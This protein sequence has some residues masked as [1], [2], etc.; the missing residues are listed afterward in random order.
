[1]SLPPLSS[2]ELYTFRANCALRVCVAVW[3]AG[4]WC[5]M[6]VRP[7]RRAAI[8]APVGTGPHRS[9]PA[10]GG[11]LVGVCSGYV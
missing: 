3:R 9:A 1:M 11:V 7:R 10:A 2:Y 5:H 8:S 6:A 4:G